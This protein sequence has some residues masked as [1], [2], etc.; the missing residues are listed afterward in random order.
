[1]QQALMATRER[2]TCGMRVKRQGVNA[3]Y[4]KAAG[5]DVEGF[6][7]RCVQRVGEGDGS[8]ARS[9]PT[10]VGSRG[11]RCWIGLIRKAPRRLAACR[12]ATD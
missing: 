2:P 10:S 4:A 12:S 7:H 5:G 9:P 8:P 1:M 11:L 3:P 6:H